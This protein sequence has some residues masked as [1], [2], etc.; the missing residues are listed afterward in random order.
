M[1][2]QYSCKKAFK[3]SSVDFT[4]HVFREHMKLVNQH[5][6]C[7]WEPTIAQEQEKGET[8]IHGLEG[9]YNKTTARRTMPK[10]SK[11]DFWFLEF[12]LREHGDFALEGLCDPWCRRATNEGRKCTSFIATLRTLC[13]MSKAEYSAGP[14]GEVKVDLVDS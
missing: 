13:G 9:D 6:S 3:K 12:I 1:N 4:K 7:C 8:I 11:D 2:Q 14:P 10:L 5:Y